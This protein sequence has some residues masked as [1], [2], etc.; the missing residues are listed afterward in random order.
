VAGTK[1]IIAQ[2]EQKLVAVNAANGTLMWESAAAPQGGGGPG[3][4]G[5]RG[6][7]GGRDYKAATP[8]IYGET[9]ITAGRGLK[10]IKLEKEGDKFV[11]K[12]LWSNPEKF[13]Q[14]NTPAV[15]D[16]M[17][18][19]LAPNNELYCLNAKDGKTVWSA[20][21]PG[22]A[23]AAAARAALDLPVFTPAAAGLVQADPAAPAN[24]ARPGGQG[25]QGGGRRGGRG[26]M[27]GGAGYGS[28]VDAGSVLFALTPGAQLI[29]FEP[30]DKEFKQVASYKV[31][32]SQTHAYPVASGNR[33]FI[34]DRDSLTLWTVE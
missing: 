23:P 34:K 2:T 20:P 13:V 15:K 19:G 25:G 1:L 21:F 33:I 17:I 6:M 27:G 24:P 9:I 26:G 30:S 8:I 22:S 18:Y 16:G 10:A 14:F 12:E 29:V 5:G 31:A 4:G 7:G 3:G 11:A 28:I 32:V